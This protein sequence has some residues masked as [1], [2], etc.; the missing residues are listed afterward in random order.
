MLCEN[1]FAAARILV[2]GDVALDRYVYGDVARISPEAPVPV[3]HVRSARASPGCAANV[4]ANIAAL[5]GHATL[6]GV[7]GSDTEAAQLAQSVQNHGAAVKLMM[8]T[9]SSRPTTVKTRF[10]A[11]GQQ[12]VR[13]D[14]EETRPIGPQ[15]EEHLIDTYATALKSCQAVILS[16]Y[17][18]GALTD[19][20]LRQAIAR[21][22]AADKP[23]LVDPKRQQLAAY[24]G[25][26][27]LK[28]NRAE[29]RAATG[30]PCDTDEDAQRAA[31]VA[32]AATG[33]MVLLT[34]AEQGI[35]LFRAGAEPVHQPTYAREVFD[36]SG[37]GDTVAAVLGIAIAQRFEMVEAMRLANAAAGVVV[38]KRGTATVSLPELSRAFSAL[39]HGFESRILP[40]DAALQ[41]RDGWRRQGL[42]VGFTNGCFDL[43]HPGHIS[44]LKEAKRC[45]DRLVV[46]L[47]SDR[48]VSRLK[49]PSRPVQ[50]E[51]ARAY[52]LAAMADVDLVTLFDTDTPIDL[53]TTLRPD[54]LIK[55]ADYTEDR[56]VGADLVRSWGGRVVLARVVPEQ[57]TTRLLRRSSARA[58]AESESAC[59][60]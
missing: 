42:S 22:A 47:N 43:I 41:Q 36:V 54:V 32:I 38:G 2:L 45:C 50:R 53:I 7:V 6:V 46:G 8:V 18:K 48:S 28:P 24:R 1:K 12:V 29:L 59:I 17:N 26:T 4:A 5:G 15:V 31:E 16:D 35:S 9:D 20:I 52:V 56:V 33:A 57:S 39:S 10:V 14:H 25:A 19:Q 11:S 30:M 27:L 13:A 49:G 55:G 23:V 37:A 60:S 34:R 40:C 58:D 44:L 3:L 21:A 51:E